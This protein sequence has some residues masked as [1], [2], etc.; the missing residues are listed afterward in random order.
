MT[1]LFLRI[2]AF[3]IANCSFESILFARGDPMWFTLI[4]ALVGMR[5]LSV[6]RL[7]DSTSPVGG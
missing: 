1:N 6:F 2:W 5:Y 4:M 7:T 3:T